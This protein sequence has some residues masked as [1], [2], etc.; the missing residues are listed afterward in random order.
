M[1]TSCPAGHPVD[2]LVL[3]VL[4]GEREQAIVDLTMAGVVVTRPE[5]SVVKMGGVILAVV[6]GV[7]AVLVLWRLLV[8]GLLGPVLL[9]IEVVGP[10]D[11][12][13][14]LG[15]LFGLA[16]GVGSSVLVFRWLGRWRGAD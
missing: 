11:P 14:Q 1:S 4:P 5:R 15:L 10:D 16:F 9:G 8:L 3:P 6:V 2:V 13:G 7:G 12:A